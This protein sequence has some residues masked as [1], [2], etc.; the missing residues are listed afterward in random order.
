MKNGQLDTKS[1]TFN[2]LLPELALMELKEHIADI[3]DVRKT[4]GMTVEDLKDFDA[5]SKLGPVEKTS[6]QYAIE[7][8][9][10]A[11]HLPEPKPLE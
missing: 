7:H 1:S 11:K 2:G 4:D 8:L 3:Y 6:I 5:R 9:N 10:L